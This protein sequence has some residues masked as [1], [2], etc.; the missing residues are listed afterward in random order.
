MKFGFFNELIV[1]KPDW[2]HK[3]S[4]LGNLSPENKALLQKFFDEFGDSR[5]IE[6]ILRIDIPNSIEDYQ[7]KVAKVEAKGF[8][9]E[10]EMSRIQKWKARIQAILELKAELEKMTSSLQ[11]LMTPKNAATEHHYGLR[12]GDRV[13][14]SIAGGGTIEGKVVHLYATDSNRCV[15]RTDDG[16]DISVVCEYCTKLPETREPYHSLDIHDGAG[17]DD[18]W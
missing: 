15:I 3:L 9:T 5:P 13:S 2:F 1:S 11:D 10:F 18:G 6:K 12:L 14:Y 17:K 8:V 4:G 7:N 16:N